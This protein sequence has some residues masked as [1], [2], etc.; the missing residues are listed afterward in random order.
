MTRILS[1]LGLAITSC[2]CCV[3]LANEPET[4]LKLKDFR[5][6]SQLQVKATSIKRAKFP[7]VDVH[8]HFEDFNNQPH[9]VDE[10]IKRMD[11]N[12]IAACVSLDGYVGDTFA[13]HK[14]LLWK[15]HKSRFIIF[16]RV[17][18]Q[19]RGEKEKPATWDMHRPDFGHQVALQLRDAKRNGAS[20]LKISKAL[21][22]NLK[23]ADGSLVTIDDKRWDPIWKA[24]GDLK[25]TVLIHIADPAAFFGPLDETNERYGELEDHPNW[26]FPASKF[27]S[28]E[29]LHTA[30]N[31][32]IARHPK[33]QFIGAHVGN[34]PED[35]ATVGEWLDTYPNFNV[36]IAARISD[37][38]RQPY[39][40]RAFMIKY[41]DRILFGT[42]GPVSEATLRIHWRFLETKDEHFAYSDGDYPHQGFWKIYGLGLPDAVLKKIYHENAARII[43]GVKEKLAA[44]R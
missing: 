6:V 33:T 40:A 32:V 17:P 2:L 21:G 15:K 24:C 37:L 20:G 27:P 36:E 3:A 12:N 13:E 1:F 19:G 22:L 38:G 26:S 14:N 11:H 35:L 34:N 41:A 18:W 5:P 10:F 44:Q 28:R 31:R 23:N 39:T 25:L 42:D 16:A 29:A 43:P 30:R 4:S 9:R 8:T 7:V